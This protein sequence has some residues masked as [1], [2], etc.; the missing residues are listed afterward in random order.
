MDAPR[1]DIPSLPARKGAAIWLLLAAC[2]PLVAGC[3]PAEPRAREAAPGSEP[4]TIISKQRV[5]EPFAPTGATFAERLAPLNA[6]VFADRFPPL[7]LAGEPQ[8]PVSVLAYAAP[9]PSPSGAVRAEAPFAFGLRGTA[10][11]QPTISAE[12]PPLPRPAPAHRGTPTRSVAVEGA[13]RLASL[14]PA[15]VISGSPESPDRAGSEDEIPALVTASARKHGV[16]VGLAHAVIKVESNYRPN[17]VGKGATM[18]L[19]QIKYATARG[20]GFTGKPK[21]LLDPATNLEWG[22]R[23]LAEAH[24]LA[25]G[26][27]CGTILRYQ[28]G[29]YAGRMTRAALLY[30]GK[31]RRLLAEF[32]KSRTADASN[33]Q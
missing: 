7:P 23:Y 3:G 4:Q 24:R 17:A 33:R 20:I 14:D 13:T 22:M 2:G 11:P 27:L 10:S 9:I 19:M 12:N 1:P 6:G 29:H 32:E 16:P 31:V 5:H 15:I 8:E 26:N 28:S 25:K 30:C 18:G 21:D